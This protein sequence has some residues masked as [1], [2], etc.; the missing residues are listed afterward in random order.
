M[1]NNVFLIRQIVQSL[2]TDFC[3]GYFMG[4]DKL[5]GDNFVR[6]K[7]FLLW[8]WAENLSLVSCKI[9][10]SHDLLWLCIPSVMSLILFREHI[11]DWA[12][13]ILEESSSWYFHVISDD[14]SSEP[15]IDAGKH[16]LRYLNFL[17]TK[18]C[19]LSILFTYYLNVTSQ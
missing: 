18:F 5:S 3:K 14:G 11:S 13:I 10:V 6:C 16:D 4:E 12:G 1:S 8:L 2:F 7:D 9:L 17:E 19:D 15:T